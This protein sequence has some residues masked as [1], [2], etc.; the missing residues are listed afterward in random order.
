MIYRE[1]P[2]CK[3]N[4]D[5]GERCSCRYSNIRIVP[6]KEI[7]HRPDPAGQRQANSPVRPE[8]RSVRRPFA[9]K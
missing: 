7:G 2:Y 3:A 5:P 4:I 8:M 9:G 6:P 1:C